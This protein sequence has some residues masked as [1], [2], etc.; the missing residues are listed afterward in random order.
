[1]KNIIVTFVLALMKRI[2]TL[3][4]EVGSHTRMEQV[5]VKVLSGDCVKQ[6]EYIL[7]I[8]GFDLELKKSEY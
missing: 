8:H 1:M 7:Q 4:Q 2:R 5:F 6:Q 3:R